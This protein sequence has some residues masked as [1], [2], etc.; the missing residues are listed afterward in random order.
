MVEPA[1]IVRVVRSHGGGSSRL[2]PRPYLSLS[3]VAALLLGLGFGGIDYGLNVLFAEGFGH[4]STAMLNI[5]NAH[6]GVGAVIGPLVIGWL[7]PGEYG[8]AFLGCAA[9]SAFLL[10]TMKGGG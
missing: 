10:L 7:P 1:G 5:L 3:L 9:L 4:R 6:F 2:R 8:L